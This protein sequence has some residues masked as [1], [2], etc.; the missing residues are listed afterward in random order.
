MNIASIQP[1]AG[2]HLAVSKWQMIHQQFQVADPVLFDKE[3]IFTKA[4]R[5]TQP[6]AAMK[7]HFDT[8]SERQAHTPG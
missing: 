7:P 6:D 8:V 4:K 3:K 1:H 2:F 5:A